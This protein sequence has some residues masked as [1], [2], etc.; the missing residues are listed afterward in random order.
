[1]TGEL[2]TISSSELLRLARGVSRGSV[3]QA[4]FGRFLP[5]GLLT[6]GSIGAY[7]G[8]QD[9]S[10]ALRI[11]ALFGY[12]TLMFSIG[13]GLGLEG[14]RRWLYPDAH[15][16]GRRSIVAGLFTPLYAGAVSIVVQ[17]LNL[18]EVGLWTGLVGMVMAVVMFFAWLTP[19]PGVDYETYLGDEVRLPATES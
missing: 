14:M 17:G 2:D 5:A 19:T 16:T 15:V 8:L 10:S 7:F 6:M 13:Y 12:E 9:P 11:A 4:T 3:F 1:M 18:V